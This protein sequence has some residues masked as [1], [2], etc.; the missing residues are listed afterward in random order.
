MIFPV[1]LARQK[2]LNWCFDVSV[3]RSSSPASG[4]WK[5]DFGSLETAEVT[6]MR[7]PQTTGLEC[8]RPG[9]A[10]LHAIFRL[11]ATSHEAGAPREVSSTP[12]APGPRKD[13]EFCPWAE[14]RNRKP[15]A[16]WVR[17]M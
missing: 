15:R 6:K 5:T 16:A 3:R 2:R 13:G 9:I 10:V 12:V 4:Y 17:M 8:P 7:S 11:A 14:A 1:R